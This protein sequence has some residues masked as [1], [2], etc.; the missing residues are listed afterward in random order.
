MCILKSMFLRLLRDRPWLAALILAVALLGV[1]NIPVQAQGTVPGIAALSGPSNTLGTQSD[2]AIW[3]AL[4]HGGAG[5]STSARPEDGV[6]VNVAG[7]WWSGLRTPSGPL[8]HYGWIALVAVL[9][10]VALFFLLRGRLRIAAG[11]SGRMVLRFSLPHRVVHWTIATLFLLMAVTGL[12][13]LFG[14]PFLIP[15]IGKNA[16]GVLASASLQLHNIFGPLFLLSLL[17]LLVTF[18]RGNFPALVDFV[19]LLR[20]GGV[21]G[22][23]VSA[24]R[25]NA[26]EKAWFWV[27]ILVGLAMSATGLMLSFPDVFGTRNLLQY[28]ELI[29]AVGALVFIGFAIGHIYLGTLG[30]EGA[31]EGMTSGSVDENWARTHHD[32]WLA[33]LEGGKEAD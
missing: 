21:L 9:G 13:L 25:Y 23:H 11:R 26:G 16:F 22:G 1:A 19:W 8:I 32:R 24:G 5:R 29:H 17:A 2:A 3:R 7:W 14:R 12:T 27:A 15:L 4:R 6:L 20:G 10:A 30:T 18:I 33:E 31:L 28:S